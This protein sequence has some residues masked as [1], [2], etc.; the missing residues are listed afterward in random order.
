MQITL[1]TK[2]DRVHPLV[3]FWIG[4]FAIEYHQRAG[5]PLFVTSLRRDTGPQP[6]PHTPGPDGLCTAFDFR[7]WALDDVGA[8]HAAVE[9]WRSRY[10][11]HLV[12]VLEPEEL[13]PAQL[14]GAHAFP[15]WA[16]HV[17]VQLR[18]PATLPLEV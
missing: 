10:G 5:R 8:A 17:H 15:E 13:A 11:A 4:V 1:D 6:S 3:W 14:E 9:A 16:P 7:R 18:L 2:Q 12:I